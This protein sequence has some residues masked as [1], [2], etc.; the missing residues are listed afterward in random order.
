MDILIN[1]N[2]ITSIKIKPKM[3]N[4]IYEWL[5][6]VPEK[7]IFFG[8]YKINDGHKEGFYEFGEYEKSWIGGGGLISEEY[9]NTPPLIIDWDVKKVFILPEIEIRFKNGDHL[10]KYF[11]TIKDAN[12]FVNKIELSSNDKFERIELI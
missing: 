6:S 9:L 7:R 4:Y 2:N 8:L 11:D 10:V 12:I 5:P 3:E 1:V